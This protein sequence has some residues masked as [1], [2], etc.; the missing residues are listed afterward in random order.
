MKGKEIEAGTQIGKINSIFI[1]VER[2]RKSQI[3]KTEEWEEGE[4]IGYG[5]CS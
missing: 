5:L 3:V 2:E 1:S 4:E